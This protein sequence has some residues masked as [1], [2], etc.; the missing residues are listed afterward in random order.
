MSRHVI[1]NKHHLMEHLIEAAFVRGYMIGSPEV[2]AVEKLVDSGGEWPDRLKP[3][4]M[5]EHLAPEQREMLKGLT[6]EDLN[7]RPDS[8]LFGPRR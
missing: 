7:H 2:Y 6:P 1:H 5:I 4:A 8:I 3:G